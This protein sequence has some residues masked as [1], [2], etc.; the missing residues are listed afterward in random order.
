MLRYPLCHGLVF[1]QMLLDDA[2]AFFRSDRAVPNPLRID[3]HPWPAG[4]NPQ[5]CRFRSQCRDVVLFQ[6]FF[7]RFPGFQSICAFTAIGA[8]AQENM[9]HASLNLHFC[10]FRR[11]NVARFLN[12]G[13]QDFIMHAGP[14]GKRR[15]CPGCRMPKLL[16]V[17]SFAGIAPRRNSVFSPGGGA[18]SGTSGTQTCFA[19]ELSMPQQAPLPIRERALRVPAQLS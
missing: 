6:K 13:N 5:A 11:E 12:H 4:A 16:A 10:E 15:N 1:E 3:Q 2:S 9:A 19:T 7:Q 17:R 8:Y 18:T 14:F